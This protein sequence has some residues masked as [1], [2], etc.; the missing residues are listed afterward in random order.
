MSTETDKQ[1]ADGLRL[2][3][4]NV[5]EG[6]LRA[7]HTCLSCTHFREVGEVCDLASN[8]CVE[9][10]VDQQVWLSRELA[11]D[12]GVEAVGVE[13]DIAAAALADLS[14]DDASPAAD[15]SA[16]PRS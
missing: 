1:I 3:A 16:A 8:T 4:K 13:L 2:L 12:Y 15:A 6:I 7:R 9:C 5:G 11:E 10:N 14:T